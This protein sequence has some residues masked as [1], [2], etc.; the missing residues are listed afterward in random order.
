MRTILDRR[1]AQK[2]KLEGEEKRKA[3]Y[4]GGWRQKGR[5][6]E[7]IEAEP[8]ESGETSCAGDVPQS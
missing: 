6:P 4:Q 1:L 8:P 5:D 2:K 3:D 7:K